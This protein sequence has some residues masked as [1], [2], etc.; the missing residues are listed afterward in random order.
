M[1]EVNFVWG[2]AVTWG[3]SQN[4]GFSPAPYTSTRQRLREIC[5][6]RP[7]SS[8]GQSLVRCCPGG[9][10]CCWGREA[11]P[12]R[13]RPSRAQRC[14]VRVSL[15]SG[16]GSFSSAITHAVLFVPVHRRFVLGV[17]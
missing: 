3:K 9:R 1:W 2:G 6:V 17:S 5:G 11:L 16:G 12:V 15:L 14:L 7:R 8:T 10:R 4:T 13:K